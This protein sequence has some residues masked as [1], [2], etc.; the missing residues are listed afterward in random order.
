MMEVVFRERARA[1][2]R[3]IMAWFCDRR[4]GSEAR[5]G[6]AFDAELSHLRR[7]PFGYQVRRAPYRFALV[8]R[9]RYVIIYAVV[10][11]AVVVYRIRHMHQR[12]L[13]RY[14]G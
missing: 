1:D 3:N 9:F 13:K 10:E 14:S 2:L 12:P 5:F 4:D 7:Y 6:A 11:G 8:G